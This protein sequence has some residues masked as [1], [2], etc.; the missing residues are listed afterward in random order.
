[1]PILVKVQAQFPRLSGLPEDEIVNVWHFSCP[2]VSA[3]SDTLADSIEQ[4]LDDFYNAVNGTATFSISS[5]MGENL[6]RTANAVVL[7]MYEQDEADLGDP[8]GSPVQTRNFTLDAAEAGEPLP[9]EVAICLSYHGDLTD[10]PETAVNPTPPPAII[11]PAARRRGRLYLGPF[12]DGANQE[13]AATKESQPQT[14]TVTA[15]TQ[16][17]IA[18]MGA[19]SADIIWVVYSETSLE[20]HEIVGGYVDNAWDIQRR[21]GNEATARTS[22]S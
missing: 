12:Q 16:S 21:R 3:L 6:D 13:D 10:V 1:M 9:P 18:L 8:W 15:I 14:A 2:L 7:S 22:W 19:N 4:R 17:A 5:K 11:R 20:L